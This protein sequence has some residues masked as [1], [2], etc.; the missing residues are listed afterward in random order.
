MGF[1]KP[2]F[3]TRLPDYS[4][5]AAPRFALALLIAFVISSAFGSIPALIVT[6]KFYTYKTPSPFS[7]FI[8]QTIGFIIIQMFL[9]LAV[10]VL[11][12]IKN[13]LVFVAGERY[14]TLVFLFLIVIISPLSFYVSTVVAT[15]LGCIAVTTMLLSVIFYLPFYMSSVIGMFSSDRSAAQKG[16]DTTFA[17]LCSLISGFTFA[18]ILEIFIALPEQYINMSVMMPPLSYY[19]PFVFCLILVVTH[20]TI[21]HVL[22]DIPVSDVLDIKRQERIKAGALLVA[23]SV[24]LTIAV[25][26]VSNFI[27]MNTIDVSALYQ[28]KKGTVAFIKGRTVWVYNTQSRVFVKFGRQK[29]LYKSGSAVNVFSPGSRQLLSAI[30]SFINMEAKGTNV[31]V[32]GSGDTILYRDDIGDPMSVFSI[33]PDGKSFFLSGGERPYWTSLIVSGGKQTAVNHSDDI[34]IA[35][36]AWLDNN[37]LYTISNKG[38]FKYSL[39]E[40]DFIQLNIVEI[41]E[42]NYMFSSLEFSDD[43]KKLAICASN[44]MFIYDTES[45]HLDVFPDSYDDCRKLRFQPGSHNLLISDSENG[46]LLFKLVN[47]QGEE[48]DSI[49]FSNVSFRNTIDPKP[50]AVQWVTDREFVVNVS[51]K[52]KKGKSVQYS[53]VNDA[54]LINM[55]TGCMFVGD[56]L[57]GPKPLFS[58]A[59]KDRGRTPI[60]NEQ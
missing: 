28:A 10:N 6:S 36:A 26:T 38:L 11:F 27:K 58:R 24:A 12:S 17:I 46:A 49:R 3:K 31:V 41:D 20:K 48:L 8:T 16:N 1:K 22:R 34:S 47:L 30:I 59:V 33:S 18:W 50:P 32:K 56:V 23:Y 55:D 54:A 29:P 21:Y 51:R 4:F 19:H 60:I 13:T 42:H 9:Y 25:L 15:G 39:M 45:G 5:R 2:A 14:K 52:I 37:T 35:D 57:I 40:E 53:E 44:E 43:A 7:Y